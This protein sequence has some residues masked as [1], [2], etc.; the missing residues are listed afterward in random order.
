MGRSTGLSN[1]LGTLRSGVLSCQLPPRN[2]LGPP[3]FLLGSRGE[4]P[5]E[6]QTQSTPVTAQ[7]PGP[8]CCDVP[9]SPTG[10]TPWDQQIHGNRVEKNH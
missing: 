5:G 8:L 10:R 6:H 2:R 3:L 9:E 1:W 4:A 7:T